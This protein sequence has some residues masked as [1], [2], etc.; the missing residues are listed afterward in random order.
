MVP[1]LC[2]SI[3]LQP[4]DQTR[5]DCC[6]CCL[7]ASSPPCASKHV[8]NVDPCVRTR[9][10]F[11]ALCFKHVWIMVPCLGTSICLLLPWSNTFVSNA[12]GLWISV[13]AHASVS[14]LVQTRLIMVACLFRLEPKWLRLTWIIPCKCLVLFVYP[15]FARLFLSLKSGDCGATCSCIASFQLL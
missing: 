12:F 8:W 5:L 3:S 7:Q 9:I 6:P 15:S 10:S 2:A 13:C 4:L 11:P 1:R 14:S